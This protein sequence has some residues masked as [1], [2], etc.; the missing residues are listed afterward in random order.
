MRELLE[1]SLLGMGNVH[2]FWSEV[3]VGG[4]CWMSE[5]VATITGPQCRTPILPSS[6]RLYTICSMK[7]PR[8]CNRSRSPSGTSRSAFTILPPTCTNVLFLP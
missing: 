6:P 1:T 7:K 8:G 4:F 5:L 3:T 2:G